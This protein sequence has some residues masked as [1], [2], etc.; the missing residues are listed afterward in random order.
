MLNNLTQSMYAMMRKQP[1]DIVIDLIP[2]T[3]KDLAC[4][5][6]VSRDTI[7]TM[8]KAI[9]IETQ[10]RLS[11]LELKRF[12]QHYGIPIRECQCQRF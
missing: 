4:E 7:R 12:Y 6:E 1:F 10:A 8:C 11:I 3:K 9:D 5:Y 2:K